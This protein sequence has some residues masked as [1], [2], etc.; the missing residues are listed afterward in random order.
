M[1]D[2][3]TFFAKLD[4]LGISSSFGHMRMNEEARLAPP[5]RSIMAGYAGAPAHEASSGEFAPG[6]SEAEGADL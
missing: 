4:E 5:R 6:A 1:W 2:G 3:R